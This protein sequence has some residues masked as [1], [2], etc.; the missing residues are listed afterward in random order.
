MKQQK[1]SVPIFRIACATMAAMALGLCITAA[2]ALAIRVEASRNQKNIIVEKIIEKPVEVVREV[3]VFPEPRPDLTRRQEIAD[4]PLPPPSPLTLPE[5]PDPVVEKLVNDA[6]RARFASDIVLAITKLNEALITSPSCPAALFEL[7]ECY[8]EMKIYDRAREAYFKVTA[9]GSEITG[10]LYE[11]ASDKL[12]NGFE[13]PIDKVNRIVLGKIRVFSDSDFHDGQRTILSIPVQ[14]DPG[15]AIHN[16]DVSMSIVPFDIVGAKKSIEPA[17][18]EGST[19]KQQWSRPN[20]DWKTGEE[21]CHFTYIIN[22]QPTHDAHL[23]GERKYYGYVVKLLY[24]GEVID[25]QAFP[26]MLAHRLN[27]R[28]DAPIEMEENMPSDYNPENPLLIPN[29]FS[30][31]SETILPIP[32]DHSTPD[33]LPPLPVP[34]QY[35]KLPSH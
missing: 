5:I 10:I 14:S 15:D 32:L 25:Q 20:P 21:I 2:V 30:N 24:K 29:D 13:L 26:R 23:F 3:A 12:A 9:L 27:L 22:P 28:G 16:N 18:A 17:R 19:Y 6:R 31:T 8:E 35:R 4:I 33:E 7:G 1:S 11:K 34:E